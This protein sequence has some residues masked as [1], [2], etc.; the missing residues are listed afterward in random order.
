MRIT[1]VTLVYIPQPFFIP[2][3]EHAVGKVIEVECTSPRVLAELD[4]S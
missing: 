2:Q 4:E 1:N 3:D